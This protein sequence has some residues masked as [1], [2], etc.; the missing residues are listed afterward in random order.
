MTAP[1]R[2]HVTGGQGSGKSTLA[3]RLAAGTGLPVHELD[4]IARIDGG[5]GPPR[6]V[7][8]RDAL[9][10]SIAGHDR[11]ITE[12]IHLGWTGLLLERAEVILWLDQLTPASASGRMVRRFLAGAMTEMR[13]RHGRQRFARIGDYLRHTRDLADALRHAPETNHPDRYASALAR[14]GAKVVRCRT[15]ADVEAFVA[16]LATSAGVPMTGPGALAETAR[17]SAEAGR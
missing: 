12:G 16:S 6:A 4:R 14:Y 13:S 5:N 17:A 11:W 8:E 2:I 15:A 7:A 10:A 9:V 3:R 1:A